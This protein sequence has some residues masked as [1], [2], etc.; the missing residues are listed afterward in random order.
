MRLVR[1]LY[2]ALE[3]SKKTNVTKV[4]G[5][6]E[7]EVLQIRS[8]KPKANGVIKLI[9]SYFNEKIN[10]IYQCFDVS[11]SFKPDASKLN[12]NSVSPV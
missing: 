7:E 4:L 6:I 5:Q 1:L 10:L 3:K 2:R 8:E 11:K 12:G 9:C